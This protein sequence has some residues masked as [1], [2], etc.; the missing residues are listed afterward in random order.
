MSSN[1]IN[2][3]LSTHRKFDFDRSLAGSEFF[4]ASWLPSHAPPPQVRGST[5]IV[6]PHIAVE[7]FS[8][9]NNEQCAVQSRVSTSKRDE[10]E[11]AMTPVR[12][13]LASL[14]S[15]DADLHSMTSAE[16]H[17]DVT[18]AALVV[19]WRGTPTLVSSLMTRRTTTSRDVTDAIDSRFYSLS[20]CTY[21]KLV[22]VTRRRRDVTHLRSLT[23]S[24]M[25]GKAAQEM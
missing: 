3:H 9:L 16:W 21:S 13:R 1:E 10:L 15:R 20:V 19:A 11:V 12:H 8:F 7:L 6:L 17:N 24:L 14:L 18:R 4:P 2:E 5:S 22:R 23:R 25:A